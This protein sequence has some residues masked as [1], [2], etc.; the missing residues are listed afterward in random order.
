TFSSGHSNVTGLCFD[1]ADRLFVTES[2]QPAGDELNLL[3]AGADYGWPASAG[4]VDGI[5][6]ATTYPADQG[7]LGGCGI[8]SRTAFVGAVDGRRIWMSVLSGSGLVIGD[9]QAFLADRYGRLCT[10]VAEPSGALWITTSNRDGPDPSADDDRV[11]R[12]LPPSDAGGG[13]S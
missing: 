12:V 3:A 13:V 7:G 11:L 10:V 2:G 5:G 1:G 6:P 4:A 8:L 9:P